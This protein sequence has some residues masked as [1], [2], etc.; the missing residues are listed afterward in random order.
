[1]RKLLEELQSEESKL[2]GIKAP[3]SIGA[4][5]KF[6]KSLLTKR[7]REKVKKTSSLTK[8]DGIEHQKD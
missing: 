5:H 8:S 1:M 7:T 2:R 4:G 3:S 6:G